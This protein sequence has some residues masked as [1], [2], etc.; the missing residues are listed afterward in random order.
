MIKKLL[1]AH[2]SLYRN[3]ELTNQNSIC[4]LCG[5]HIKEEDA[6]LDHDHESGH[7]R[8][9]LHRSCNTVEG[10]IKNAYKRYVS[11]KG[12]VS[13]TEFLDNLSNYLKD[14]YSN[15]PIHP[16]ELTPLEAELKDTN[17]KLKKVKQPS[18][19]QKYKDYAKELR[20]KI[21]EERKLSSWF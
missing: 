14:D 9:V 16:T 21:K 3:V 5:H 17:K 7:C 15:N 20:Q 19:V 1:S 11:G 10:K 4:P 6:V 12:D 2:L 13:F 8:R 18:I